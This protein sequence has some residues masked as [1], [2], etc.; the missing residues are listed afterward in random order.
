M[1]QPSQTSFS[2]E[3]PLHFIENEKYNRKMTGDSS[4]RNI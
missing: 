1:I 4:I 2:L 3:G